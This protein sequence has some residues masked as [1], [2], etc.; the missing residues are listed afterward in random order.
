MTPASDALAAALRLAVCSAAID[1]HPLHARGSEVAWL[2]YAQSLRTPIWSASLR[3]NDLHGGATSTLQCVEIGWLSITG[4]WRLVDSAGPGL[5]TAPPFDALWRRYPGPPLVTV[6]IP[7]GHW[8]ALHTAPP[9]PRP[10]FSSSLC[11]RV[12]ILVLHVSADPRF[13]MDSE[14]RD[15]AVYLAK[16]AEQAE[17]Y[18]GTCALLV[19]TLLTLPRRLIGRACCLCACR[20]LAGVAQPSRQC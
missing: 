6:S 2:S 13:K 15:K 10:H 7:R 1:D 16:L 5:L 8:Q 19:L 20:A 14:A 18:D 3:A 17:R 4:R 11:P 9:L 12:P